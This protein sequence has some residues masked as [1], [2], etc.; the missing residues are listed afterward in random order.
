MAQAPI[1]NKAPASATGGGWLV[2]FVVALFFA[3]GFATVLIDAL[4]PKLK[5]LFALNYAET[6]LTQ[7]AFFIAYFVVSIPA[8]VLLSRIGYLW[9]VVV[10]LVVMAAGCLLFAPAAGAGAY[11]GYLVALFIMASG[12]TL[13]QVAANPLIAI[14]GR[15]DRSHFRLN[16]AQA[17]NSLGTF[18]GPFVGA[19][20]IL[21]NGITPP[22]PAHTAPEVLAAYRVQEAHAVQSPFLG[23]ATGLVLLALI[24]WLFRKSPNVPAAARNETGLASFR[25]LTRPRLAL[26]VLCIFLYVGAEVSIG[27]LMT[28]Y[29]LEP[30]N[31]DVAVT[32]GN[33][34]HGFLTGFGGSAAALSAAAAAGTLVAFYWG[35][36]MVGRIVGSALLYLKVPATR[37][38]TACAIGAIALVLVSVTGSGVVSVAA[39]IA[40]GLTNSIMFPTIF[41]L[42]IEGMGDK[43]P[44]ASGLLC[45]AIVGGAIV[46]LITGKAADHIGL[47]LALLTPAACYVAIALYGLFS[48]NHQVVNEAP[49]APVA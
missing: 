39:I 12:I 8:A 47:S 2:P 17:F 10:G 31:H 35:G 25:L 32:A 46:P 3:W 26:G 9:G 42:G 43:T 27:S 40:V 16:M 29:L 38:L 1:A 11:W 45:M 44:Q 13:L 30:K 36:A 19:A 24:F 41:T 5:G 48:H 49:E 33:A 15:E 6:M 34:I 4:A 14:L 21:K 7:F 22:D 18:I 20:V 23:I 37:L 28:N